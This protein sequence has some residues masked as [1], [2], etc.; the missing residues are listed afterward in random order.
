[1]FTHL[2]NIAHQGNMDL[3]IIAPSDLF[4]INVSSTNLTPTNLNIV[5]H[6][7]MVKP[8][9]LL[10]FFHFIK[11]PRAQNL[12]SNLTMVQTSIKTY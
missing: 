5:L 7:Q 11:F 12:G 9:K 2:Q 4:Q 8:Y 1:L 3:L 6:V 10:K